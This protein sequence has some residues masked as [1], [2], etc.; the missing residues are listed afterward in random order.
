M[1]GPFFGLTMMSYFIYHTIYGNHGLI[2]W[3]RFNKD[4]EQAERNL[5]QIEKTRD[6]LV[7]C[8]M[9][10]HPNSLDPDLLEER[11][12]LMLNMGNNDDIIIFRPYF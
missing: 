11:A 8:V 6:N 2:A 12:R 1:I 9:L 7:N 5:A 4:I 10:L 3:R